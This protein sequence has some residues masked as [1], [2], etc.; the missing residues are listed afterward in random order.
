MMSTNEK[1]ILEHFFLTKTPNYHFQNQSCEKHKFYQL[2]YYY[3]KFWNKELSQYLDVFSAV[4][5]EWIAYYDKC[6]MIKAATYHGQRGWGM[7]G[8]NQLLMRKL[9]HQ[10]TFV[11]TVRSTCTPYQDCNF[12]TFFQVVYYNN[13]QWWLS[14]STQSYN[15]NNHDWFLFRHN[16]CIKIG[17]SRLFS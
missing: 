9:R 2:G 1:F 14:H 6:L 12:K 7:K 17:N 3:K 11:L 4:L 16:V 13:I 5:K 10:E 15:K 8:R